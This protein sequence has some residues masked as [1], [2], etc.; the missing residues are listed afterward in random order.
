MLFTIEGFQHEMRS[1]RFFF[2]LIFAMA[3]AYAQAVQVS[4]TVTNKTTGKPAVGD[5]LVMLDVQA[6]MNEAAHAT[7]DSRGH[8]SISAP[9]DGPYLIRVTHQGAGYF[10]AA[11]PGGGSGDIPVY[12]VAAKVQGVHIEADVIEAE[13]DNG[14]LKV[15]ERYFVHNT[16]VPPVTQWSPKS[17]E[18]VLPPGAVL[19]GAG[20]QRPGGLP[21]SINLDPAGAKGRYAFNFP[22]QPDDGDKDT[23]FQVSYSLPY[24]DGKFAFQSVLTMPSDNFAVLL[25]KSMTFTPGSG[26]AFKPVNE[27]PNVQTLL[28]RNVAAD[29]PVEFT[30]SGQGAIPRDA[31]G[32]EAGPQGAQ[33]A[34]GAGSTPGGGIGEPIDT[35]DPL[36]KYKWWILGGLA[37]LLAATAAFLLRRP[38]WA[39]AGAPAQAA[40]SYDAPISMQSYAPAGGK[41]ALL[42]ALKE[43]LFAIESEKIAGTLSADDYAE[44]K[45]ALETVLKRALK[46][47]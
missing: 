1:T 31:Q 45:A 37:L 5:Q 28:M 19:A 47:R 39:V 2:L 25:P 44:Q 32:G 14:Q 40:A 7:T 6:G 9:G 16:S 38:A 33:A 20:A 26:A 34:G 42:N 22:I 29:T 46:K 10:I 17:F 4:G 3:G 43:E 30:L 13:S 41:S 35:P 21:T 36:S 8:Y 27:D 11:A 24:P 12:D 23:M 18:I 15:N